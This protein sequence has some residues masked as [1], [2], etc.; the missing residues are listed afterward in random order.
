MFA[1]YVINLRANILHQDIEDLY[2]LLEKFYNLN[3]LYIYTEASPHL[4][5]VPRVRHL[6][7]DGSCFKEYSQW[8]EL[9]SLNCPDLEKFELKRVVLGHF[10]EK[11]KESLEFRNL[12]KIKLKNIMK[13]SNI[14]WKIF[15]QFSWCQI[16][17]VVYIFYI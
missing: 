13:K 8:Y 1:E 11:K 9:S 7:F 12:K 2:Y 15:K 16:Q 5:I 4:L 6:I 14:K 10:D 17:M 3:K